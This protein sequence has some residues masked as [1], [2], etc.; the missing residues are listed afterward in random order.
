M[1]KPSRRVALAGAAVLA[2]AAAA[3][4][5]TGTAAVQADTSESAG[6]GTVQAMPE[7]PNKW[8]AP[9]PGVAP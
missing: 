2:A 5:T 8:T 7:G 9:P 4:T 3:A 6:S 1:T